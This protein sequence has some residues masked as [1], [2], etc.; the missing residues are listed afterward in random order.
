MIKI[1]FKYVLL[2][3][4]V[5]EN[6]KAFSQ[7]KISFTPLFNHQELS[8]N[9]TYTVENDSLEINKFAFYISNIELYLDNE[10]VYELEQKHFLINLDSPKSLDISLKH[11]KDIVYNKLVFYIGIDSI[12]NVSGAFG[13]DLDPTN[14]MYWTW[15]SGYINF[16]LEG[17]CCACEKEKKDFEFHIGGY[18]Y[19]YNS[20]RKVELALNNQNDI[21]VGID[22][23]KLLLFIQTNNI[24]SVMSPSK[25]AM[26]IADVLVNCFAIL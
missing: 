4:L 14:G 17:I 20:Y 8:F 24:P 13:G 22:A 7:D 2:L 11:N 19:P 10:K 6:T 23:N 21:M 9:S 1:I 12:T 5:V 26:L 25:N 18:Q 16:K 15:Q 3:I